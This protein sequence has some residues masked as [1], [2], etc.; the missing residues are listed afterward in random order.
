MQKEKLFSK[1]LILLFLFAVLACSTM[2][3]TNV[4]VPLFTTEDLGGNNTLAGLM[5]TLCVL[6]ACIF[7]LISS[8]LAERFGKRLF[9][10]IG[11]LTYAVSCLFVG[12]FPSIIVL[13]ICRFLMGI[14]YSLGHTVSNNA[15]MDIIPAS[16]MSEGVGYFGMA[17]SVGS[18][19]G[20]SLSTFVIL[21]TD[22]RRSFFIVSA[23]CAVGVLISLF[24]DYEK[25]DQNYIKRRLET[26]KEKTHSFKEWLGT[27]YEKTAFT[28]SLFQGLNMF[29]ISMFTCFMTLY[30]VQ[31]GLPSTIAGTYFLISS[32]VII[33]LRTLASRFLKTL[34]VYA[35]TT[36]GYIFFIAASF[37]ALRA[38]TALAFYGSAVCFGM[39]HGGVWMALGSEAIRRA[40]PEKKGAANA[41][42][43]LSFDLFFSLGATTW[44]AI[45]DASG[46][47]LCF[48]IVMV[49]AAVLATAIFLVYRKPKNA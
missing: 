44:G 3:M 46:Y 8:S 22:N 30:V 26:V 27:I 29:F 42:F 7:R 25:K 12:L 23:L 16:R 11:I 48:K 10:F 34:P 14:G 49:A 39:A 40:A 9:L 18:A 4:I 17:A 1:N 28:A 47:E 6:T 38:E 35:F 31:K 36:V 5:S 20:P 37:I 2:G 32:I 19:I 21:W 13:I 43:Y 33:L 15:A 45:I 41:M 24:I